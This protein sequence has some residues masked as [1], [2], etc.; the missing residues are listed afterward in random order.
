MCSV[1]CIDRHIC[2]G[3]AAEEFFQGSR[4]GAGCSAYFCGESGR[5]C[6]SAVCSRRSG[7]NSYFC[8]SSS[9]DG[10]RHLVCFPG[11][12]ILLAEG[13]PFSASD[14]SG[15]AEL[16]VI[17]ERRRDSAVDAVGLRPHAFV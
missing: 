3:T 17:L 6:Y 12:G 8:A 7:R 14:S 1:Y 16:A 5:T 4:G 15:H 10:G 2:T 11:G 13:Q 9:D